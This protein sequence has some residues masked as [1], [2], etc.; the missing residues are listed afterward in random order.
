MLV[1]VC[2]MREGDNIREVESLGIDLMGFI[3]FKKSPRYVAQMADY[4]PANLRRVGVFVDESLEVIC[5]KIVT[6]G[7][8]AVQLHGGESVDMCRSIRERGVEVFKA[9]SISSAADLQLAEL[10]DG[11]C[12]M[13]IFDTKC[14][15]FGGSGEQ[16]DWSILD[17]YSGRTPFLLSGGLSIDSVQS[18]REF[19]HPQL[20]GYD[21]NSRFESAPAVKDSS[22]IGEFVEKL[23][24]R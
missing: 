8:S 15:G 17:G 7:L 1:K 11:E 19:S 3:F 6:F 14:E 9:I 4:M 10:Y 20:A 23:K 18:L 24:K 13:L 22:L 16:F 21:I 5:E 12:D 2:G